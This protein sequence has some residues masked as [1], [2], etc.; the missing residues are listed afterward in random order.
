VST[1]SSLL[2][3]LC[4]HGLFQPGT[5]ETSTTTPWRPPIEIGV[6]VD[7]TRFE[8]VASQAAIAVGDPAPG[9]TRSPCASREARVLLAHSEMVDAF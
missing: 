5:T 7:T 6:G 2:P 8:S 1:E 4:E 9:G 3:V